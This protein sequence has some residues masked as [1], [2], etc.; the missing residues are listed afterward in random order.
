MGIKISPIEFD[1]KGV[2]NGEQFFFEKKTLKI[3]LKKNKKIDKKIKVFLLFSK[4]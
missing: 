1:A 2:D 3:S 4:F